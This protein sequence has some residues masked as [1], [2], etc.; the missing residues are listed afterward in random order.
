MAAPLRDCSDRHRPRSAACARKVSALFAQALAC[1][2]A[3]RIAKAISLYNQI[4]THRPDLSQCH[5]NLGAA[6]ASLGKFAQAAAAYRQAIALKPDNAEAHSNLGVTLANLGK[7]DAAIAAFRR[8]IACNPDFAGAHCNL[9]D[10]LRMTGRLEASEAACRKAIALRADYPEA[11][12]N[13]GNTLKALGRLDEA[14]AMLRRAITLQPDNAEAYSSLGTVLMDLGRHDDAEA[15]L[16]QA[17]TI[18]PDCAGAYNNLGLVLKEGGRLTQAQ[19]AAEQAV[20]LAPAKPLHFVNLGEVRRYAAGDRYIA[21]LE[22]LATDP[23]SLAVHDRVCLHFALAKAYADIGRPADEFSQLLAGNALKRSCIPYDEAATLGRLDRVREVFTAGLI[24]AA[25]GAGDPSPVPIFIVGML[26]SGTTLLEQILASH[27]GIFGGGELKLFEQ[28][29]AAVRGTLPGS[30]EFP[31]MARHM[32]GVHFGTL[33]RCYLEQ[34]KRR[35]PAASHITD[36]MPSNFAFAG[37]IH[38]AL[39]NA[40]IIHAV[41]HP[42]DTCVSCFSKLFTEGQAHTY[43]L[44]ELGRYYRHYLAVMAHWRRVLPAGRILEVRYEDMVADLEG[45]ARRII[46]H[47]GL[48]WDPRCLA[49]HRTERP[50]STASATQ[51]RQPIYTSAVGRWRAYEPFL[52]PL[53]AEL[54]DQPD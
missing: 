3:G 35:A 17:I 13:L 5:N 16:R 48:D 19:W 44:T 42:V 10:T 50:V 31:E 26:R 11:H 41:R 53:L 49:F 4:L 47:C 46:A 25:G 22:A 1:Q 29:T 38:L 32:S 36:K 6:F 14:E 37:A 18:N 51:V 9:A 21:A 39:P 20:R 24:D 54:S 7:L 43:D 34:I 33:G 40:I 8:A 27:P 30:P 2:Q 12:A 52:G 45:S 28:A 23:A 15:A